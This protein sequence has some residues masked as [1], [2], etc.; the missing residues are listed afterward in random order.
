MEKQKRSSQQ[1]DA[2]Q[3]NIIACKDKLLLSKNKK[4]A[5][6]SKL[7]IRV[8]EVDE[9]THQSRQKSKKELHKERAM[10][11]LL[12]KEAKQSSEKREKKIVAD[13]KEGTQTK[14][15]RLSK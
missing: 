9:R 13:C 2:Y 12:M 10:H 8:E 7:K 4:V 5:Q 3:K 15:S 6:L 1:K 11:S 14:R